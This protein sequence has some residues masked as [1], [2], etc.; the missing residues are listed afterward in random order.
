MCAGCWVYQIG[1]ATAIPDQI[2][3]DTNCVSTVNWGAED[4]TIIQLYPV[5]YYNQLGSGQGT[6]INPNH[7]QIPEFI[8]WED[9]THS[10]DVK[11]IGNQCLLDSERCSVP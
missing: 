3:T 2:K 10:A 5:G 4:N 7:N 6:T 8:L 9:C 11:R 1:R